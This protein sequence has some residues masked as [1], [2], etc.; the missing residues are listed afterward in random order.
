MM[1]IEITPLQ[2]NKKLQEQA[3]IFLLDVRS[4]GEFKIANLNGHLIELGELP[5][6]IDELNLNQHIIVYCHHGVRSLHAAEFLRARG[7]KTVQSLQ[8]GVDAWAQEIDHS[9]A[10]Y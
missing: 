9:M 5:S 6:R 10:R 7:A 4:I 3:D 8:G 2:L 1:E